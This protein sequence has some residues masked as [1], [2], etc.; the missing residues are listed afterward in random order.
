MNGLFLTI[1]IVLLCTQIFGFWYF[2]KEIKE[3]NRKNK[4]L[5]L[6]FKQ[7]IVENKNSFDDKLKTATEEAKS[8]TDKAMIALSKRIG[9]REKPTE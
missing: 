8:H 7:R 9:K 1:C 4:D 5:E 2:T 3:L 6:N